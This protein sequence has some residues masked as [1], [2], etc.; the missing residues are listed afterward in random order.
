MLLSLIQ[1]TIFGALLCLGLGMTFALGWS[2]VVGLL[3]MGCLPT[4][5]AANFLCGRR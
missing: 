3:L 1:W 4:L 5:L 2:F